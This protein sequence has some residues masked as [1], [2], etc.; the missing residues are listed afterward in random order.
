MKIFNESYSMPLNL[1]ISR[2]QS[3][4]ENKKKA[5]NWHTCICTTIC[6][7]TILWV[8]KQWNEIKQKL[9]NNINMWSQF[10]LT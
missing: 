2:F 5:S 8:L 4:V 3:P 9:G 7:V 6:L 10:D 1:K